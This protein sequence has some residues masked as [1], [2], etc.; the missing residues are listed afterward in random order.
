MT[1]EQI[2]ACRMQT[3]NNLQSR[4]ESVASTLR[5]I[6]DT[7]GKELRRLEQ[8]DRVYRSTQ[9]AFLASG[10]AEQLAMVEATQE[11]AE[12]IAWLTGRG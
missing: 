6:I 4:R 9:L 11:Q 3:E 10:L 7:A 8:G 2:Q 1:A 12:M 5:E